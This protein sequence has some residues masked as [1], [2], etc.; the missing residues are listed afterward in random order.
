VVPPLLSAAPAGSVPLLL[1]SLTCTSLLKPDRQ[2]RPRSL[3]YE[4]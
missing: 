2:A 4:R 3:R 1:P